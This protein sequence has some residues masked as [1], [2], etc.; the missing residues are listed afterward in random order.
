[1]VKC[2][3]RRKSTVHVRTTEYDGVSEMPILRLATDEPD[4]I[5]NASEAKVPKIRMALV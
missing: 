1:M 5:R 4:C 2:C 3:V